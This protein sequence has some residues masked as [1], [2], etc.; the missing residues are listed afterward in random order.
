MRITND[1]A[2][3]RVEKHVIVRSRP[4]GEVSTVQALGRMIEVQALINRF[5]EEVIWC[6]IVGRRMAGFGIIA[7]R[8]L[9]SCR[10][11][12]DAFVVQSAWALYPPGH[13]ACP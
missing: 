13:A 1:C 6:Y 12:R 9:R 5:R 7:I 3:A 8:A 4:C 2:G 10:G 11:L